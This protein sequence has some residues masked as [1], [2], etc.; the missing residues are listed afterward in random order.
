MTET[1]DVQARRCGIPGCTRPYCCK[2]LCRLH[3]E[4]QHRTG[5]TDDPVT[6]RGTAHPSWKG[7]NV[8]YKAVHLRMSSGPRP[9]ECAECGTPDGR[10]EWAL[11]PDVPADALLFSPEGYPYSTD[12]GHYVNLCKQCHN[13]LDLGRSRCRSGHV[14]AGDNLYIQPSNGKRFCRPCMRARRRARHDRQLAAK[15]AKAS[16]CIQCGEAFTQDRRVG[17]W[18]KRCPACRKQDAHAGAAACPLFPVPPPEERTT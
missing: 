13:E 3:W 4:R 10:F 16:G 8:T 6:P 7:D 9:G 12:P 14:L 5:S 2:G 18:A 1:V 11:R 15:A 17:R